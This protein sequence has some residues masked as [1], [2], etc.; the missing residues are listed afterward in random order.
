MSFILTKDVARSI[1]QS[2]IDCLQSRLTAIQQIDG[3]PMGIECK[4]FGD[5]TAFQ[6]KNI[7]GPSYNKILGL[8]GD[9]VAYID[10]ILHF[11][12]ESEIPATFDITPAHATVDLLKALADKGYVQSGFH[13]VLYRS[14]KDFC[15]PEFET[16]P[17]MTIRELHSDEFNVFGEIYTTGFGMPSF[18]SEHVATNNRVLHH[19]QNW[20]FYIALYDGEPAG[21]GVFYAKNGIGTLAA[22]ATLPAFRNKGVH[23]ALVATRIEKAKELNC[24]LLV[25][26]AAFGSASH[27]N[28]ER[29]GMRIAYTKGIWSSL[30]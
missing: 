10:S 21:I 27:R 15:A 9:E 20:N 4:N 14:L 18:L 12:K 22:S 11:Y 7:S 6:A 26:Q 25:G 23:Q 24:S 1:E 17:L 2:E 8:S 19:H 28:M 29:T 5:A 30:H 13:T 3:N 16:D